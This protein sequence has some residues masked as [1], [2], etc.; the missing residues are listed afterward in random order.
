MDHL[1]RRSMTRVPPRS[2]TTTL[3]QLPHFRANLAPVPSRNVRFQAVSSGP[4]AHPAR[5]KH[6][7]ESRSTMR[8]TAQ[9]SQKSGAS[10][11]VRF[12]A[13]RVFKTG[14]FNRSATLPSAAHGEASRSA[15]R[16]R[17]RS[18]D[19]PAA[20]HDGGLFDSSLAG[21]RKHAGLD[22]RLRLVERGSQVGCA[23]CCPVSKP[24]QDQLV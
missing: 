13:G 11:K 19:H 3:N 17:E 2:L 1:S 6:P 18:G 24:A 9:E 10:S 23:L 4:A 7:A 16:Q 21:E 12:L 8:K 20:G 5:H 14:A 15:S 22:A